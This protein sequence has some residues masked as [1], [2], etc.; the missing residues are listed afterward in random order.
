MA[1]I[2]GK[3]I[4]RILYYMDL[5]RPWEAALADDLLQAGFVPRLVLPHGGQSDMVVWQHEQ[6]A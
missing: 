1:A 4:H 6:S 5:S 3:G 2:R